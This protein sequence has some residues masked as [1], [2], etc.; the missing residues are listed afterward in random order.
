[1]K[2]RSNEIRI[3]QEPPVLFK[4]TPIESSLRSLLES[5]LVKLL[6]NNTIMDRLGFKSWG[7]SI[8][9]SFVFYPF[10]VWIESAQNQNAIYGE[11]ILQRLLGQEVTSRRVVNSQVFIML[12]GILSI[13]I[14]VWVRLGFG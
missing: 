10:S 5:L 2:N 1:M 7:T 14:L 11:P 8:N 13:Y 6:S 4:W 12:E 9:S 3:R